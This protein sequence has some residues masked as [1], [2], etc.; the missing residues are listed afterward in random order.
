MSKSLGFEYSLK[1]AG[2]FTPILR[3]EWMSES[4]VAVDMVIL[5]TPSLLNLF[6][7]LPTTGATELSILKS[8]TMIVF[9]RKT[10]EMLSL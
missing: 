6:N 4:F 3:R 1:F 5:S 2:G 8:S 7:T 10:R 9:S